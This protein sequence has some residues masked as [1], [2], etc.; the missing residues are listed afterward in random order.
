MHAGESK[1][2]MT[3]L[4]VTTE[5]LK[6]S[7]WINPPEISFHF[8]THLHGHS[9]SN[10][11]ILSCHIRMEWVGCISSCECSFPLSCGQQL[12]NILM[13]CE[14]TFPWP[15]FCPQS[16]L[17]GLLTYTH[18]HMTPVVLQIKQKQAW[19]LLHNT[20]Q[21][22]TYFIIGSWIKIIWDNCNYCIHYFPNNIWI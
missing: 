6:R 17:E 13:H 16:E 18:T 10:W 7:D 4:I 3:T 15:I 22:A 19:C 8:I 1:S 20:T 5:C 9:L 21:P 2:Q 14:Q 12:L 11:L